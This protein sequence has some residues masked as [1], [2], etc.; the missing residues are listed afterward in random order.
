MKIKYSMIFKDFE[1]F[2]RSNGFIMPG[3]HIRVYCSRTRQ[4]AAKSFTDTKNIS[5]FSGILARTGA[6][7]RNV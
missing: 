5:G 3:S 4:N 1:I 2:P 6:V 7:C